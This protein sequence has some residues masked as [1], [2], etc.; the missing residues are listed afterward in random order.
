MDCA[1]EPQL[2][3][4]VMTLIS[5]NAIFHVSRIVSFALL[6]VLVDELEVKLFSNRS[7]FLIAGKRGST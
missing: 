7:V 3:W 5:R 4:C 1:L 6:L 2:K